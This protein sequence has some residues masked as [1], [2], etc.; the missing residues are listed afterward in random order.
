M[1]AEAVSVPPTPFCPAC[2]KPPVMLLGG[3]T[4]AFCGDSACRVMV[5]NPTDTEAQFWATAAAVDLTP[6]ETPT[7]GTDG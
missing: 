3:G 1:A 6:D 7:A 5:W 4:Q 2:K